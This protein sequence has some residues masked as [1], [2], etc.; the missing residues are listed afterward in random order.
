ML[1]PFL[2]TSI[3]A[4][5]KPDGNPIFRQTTTEIVI[6]SF[7]ASSQIILEIS[8]T[9]PTWML[10]L[11]RLQFGDTPI[12]TFDL[13]ILQAGSLIRTGQL[14]SDDIDTGIDTMVMLRQATPLRLE[15][16]NLDPLIAHP[17]RCTQ[18]FV[19]VDN[20]DDWNKFQAYL[21][22]VLL[23]GGVGA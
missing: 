23:P 21:N 19:V 1:L 17:F 13:E 6:P 22:Q 14:T 2:V 7:A 10:L 5:T 20:Q 11:Y 3:L 8:P 4:R 12:N 18:S 16:T 15:I 9:N